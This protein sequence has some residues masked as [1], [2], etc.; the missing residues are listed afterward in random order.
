MKWLVFS[1]DR[2][3]QLDAFIRSAVENGQIEKSDITVLHR[4]DDK[5]RES[6][7]ALYKEHSECYFLTESDFKNQVICWV[8][9]ADSLI[10][11]ATDDAVFT[12]SVEKEAVSLTMQQNPS[13]LTFSLRLGMHLD[14]CYPTAQQ[15]PIPSGQVV[16]GIFAWD[17]SLA[18]G[19][20]GYPLSVDGHVFRPAEILE[21]LKRAEYSNP[22][23]LEA[24]MQFYK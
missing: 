2:P 23:T 17:S 18:S 12:R 8:E 21:I 22:N 16:S 24:S 19:D 13:V 6:L 20:W 9:K 11:F 14:Y 1:K 3:Y 7:E 5:Y 15:Q 4:Y 10:S